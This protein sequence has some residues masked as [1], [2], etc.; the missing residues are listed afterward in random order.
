MQELLL[1]NTEDN[2]DV[3]ADIHFNLVVILELTLAFILTYVLILTI[4]FVPIFSMMPMSIII[5]MA[6]QGHVQV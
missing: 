3:V 1:A 5:F 4:K 2:T 6:V